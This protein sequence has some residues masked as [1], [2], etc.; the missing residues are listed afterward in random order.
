MNLP[1][2]A[3]WRLCAFALNFLSFILFCAKS[4]EAA[5][6]HAAQAQESSF[7]RVLATT[8]GAFL[9][10]FSRDF[11]IAVLVFVVLFKLADAL[12]ATLSTK[13]ILDMG[14]SRVELATIYKGVGFIATLSGGFA[15]GFVARVYPIG[16]SLL[17]GDL[18]TVTILA[19]SWQAVVGR[20]LAT[21]TFA[22]AIESFTGAI[23]TVIFVAYLSALC[24]SPLHT[25]TQ[26]ALLTALAAVGRTVFSLGAGYVALATGWAWFSSSAPPAAIPSFVLLAWLQRAR[27]I[28]RR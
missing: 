18:Q 14:F 21:L 11:A 13:F 26:Y 5:A 4:A 12:A 3:T 9:D 20:D 1:F 10:F 27:A 15:G 24:K 28:S 8:I 23:G 2:L 6:A 25:A 22:I 7:R 17:I 16:R 19:F